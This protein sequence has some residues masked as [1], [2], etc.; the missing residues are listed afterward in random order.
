MTRPTLTQATGPA[1][2]RI[3]GLGAARGENVV[4]NDDLVGPIDSSDEWIRQ[5]TGIVTRARSGPGTDVLDLAE[6]AGRQAIENA[7]LQGSD[8]DAVILAT[9]TYFHQTPSGAAILADRLGATPAAAFDVSAACAGYCYGIGQ[10][11]ALVRAGSARHVLVIGAEKMSDFID[12]TDRSI[13]FLLGDG[14][15]AVVI[16]PS[17]APGIG[18]TVWGSDGSQSQAI[19]QT[20]SWID[21]RDGG[22]GWP[23]LRQEGPSVFK[24]AVW[25]MAPVAQKALDAAG[26]TADDIDAFIPHQ[27]NMRIIDQMIK[28]LKLP[29]TVAVA[30]DIVDTGNT[31][32]ASIPLA[33]ERMLREGQVSSGALALQIGF[34]AGL[35]YAAQ[36]VVLP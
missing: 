34:G 19:R 22:A 8:I 9:V 33:T 31:S 27:A 17:D 12:P 15:G 20:H 13:S 2:T 14:A 21:V 35:V 30:R 5:R 23:T 10:A 6:R 3:L 16:G 29:E 32:A 24:W 7:G 18:P 11:D 26:V 1:H 28:Q 4:P 25:Q 36:V